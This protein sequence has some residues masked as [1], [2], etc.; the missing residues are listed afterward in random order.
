MNENEPFMRI[1][2]D[3]EEFIATRE[4]TVLYTFLGDLAM[5]DHVYLVVDEENSTASY[6]FSTNPGYAP[7]KAYMEENQ[8]CM[9]LNLPRVCDMDR[10]VF[11]RMIENS[12]SDID[13][14]IPEDWQ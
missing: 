8:Y 14:G 5:Y 13:N 10:K 4:N 6:V 2:F 1:Q 11:D 9:H 7:M 3:G 12:V